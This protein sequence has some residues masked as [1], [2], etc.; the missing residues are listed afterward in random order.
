MLSGTVIYRIVGII[1]EA[2]KFDDL[3]KS[4]WFVN[5]KF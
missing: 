4:L 2:F 5:I 3:T 1:D